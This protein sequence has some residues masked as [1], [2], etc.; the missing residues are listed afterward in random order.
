MT[1]IQTISFIFLVLFPLFEAICYIHLYC[2]RNDILIR[3]RNKSAIYVA[4]AAG[5][6]AYLNVIVSLFGGVPC[7]V[8]YVAS[9]LVAP[10]SVG[11]QIVRAFTLRGTMQFSQLVVEDEISSRN[12]RM[13]QRKSGDTGGGVPRLS[14]IPS[15]SEQTEGGRSL[16]VLMAVSDEANLIVEKTKR[17]ALITKLALSII[18]TIAIILALVLTSDKN[19]LSA[20]DECQDPEPTSFQYTNP[21]FC[22]TFSILAFF[23]SMFVKPLDDELHIATELRRDAILL[24][25]TYVIIVFV[26]L[27]GYEEWQPLLQTVQQMMLSFSMGIMPFLPSTPLSSM[28]SWVDTLRVNPATKSAAPGYG[29]PLPKE[30]HFTRAS[31]QQVVMRRQSTVSG[32]N[33]EMTVSWDA[34]LAILLSSSDG[35]NSFSQHCAREFSSENVR[36]WCAVND[37]KAQFGDIESK[38]GVATSTEVS[39]DD[40]SVAPTPQPPPITNITKTKDD[41]IHLKLEAQE[42]YNTFI[43]PRGSAQ[44]NLSS[45]Q[46]TDVKSAIDSG[47]LVR[48]TFDAAQKEIFS[49]MSRDSYP[50]YLASKKNRQL[51]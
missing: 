48:E 29:R 22:V 41:K 4:S 37:Y 18:P 2:K 35:I 11:P 8:F 21:V 13:Q 20:T 3:K 43:D 27:A 24:G 36:F 33:R 46:R 6:L 45:K 23:L 38:P 40:N 16:T 32:R 51:R 42:I 30:R 1:A 5:W 17:L 34:G 39:D 12:S 10:L 25:V 9:L 31:I 50:R 14:T 26:R 19:Q 7:G 28:V 47:E 49:V 44:V 15:G